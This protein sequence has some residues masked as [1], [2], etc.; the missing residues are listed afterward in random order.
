[1]IVA[2]HWGRC[3]ELRIEISLPKDVKK[4]KRK[5]KLIEL[6]ERTTVLAP[7]VGVLDWQPTKG[8]IRGRCMWPRRDR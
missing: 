1:M 6:G 4:V 2:S 5:R 7:I 8:S 3:S